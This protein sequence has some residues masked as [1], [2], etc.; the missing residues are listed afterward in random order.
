MLIDNKHIKQAIAQ[1]GSYQAQI[2]GAIAIALNQIAKNTMKQEVS[3]TNIDDI[4]IKYNLKR[5][6]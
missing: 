2:L 3:S 1:S 4:M 6:T 5:F